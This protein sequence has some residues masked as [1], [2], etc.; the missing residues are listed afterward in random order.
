MTHGDKETPG[1][2]PG[3]V[4]TPPGLGDSGAPEVPCPALPRSLSHPHQHSD[5]FG[6]YKMFPRKPG[7]REVQDRASGPRPAT[8][9]PG[10]GAA[11]G[12]GWAAPSCHSVREAQDALAALPPPPG[13]PGPASA[14]GGGLR[15]CGREPNPAVRS[16]W[17]VGWVESPLGGVRLRGLRGRN[18]APGLCQ[19]HPAS[20]GAPDLVQNSLSEGDRAE[21]SRRASR[22][23]S[24]AAQRRPQGVRPVPG[25]SGDSALLLQKKNLG[26]GFGTL[27]RPNTLG[28]PS[29]FFSLHVAF[30]GGLS[31][32]F[33]F[34]APVYFYF[35]KI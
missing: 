3:E 16:D 9:P 29:L 23:S 28:R 7:H 12:A 13:D 15:D 26:T 6:W 18:A 27:G 5:L 1:N 24:A 35:P 34:F 17:V 10:S 19:R 21:R 20:G 30:R 11:A 25:P 31:R 33:V 2:R 22:A 4:R 32:G 8:R 14:G